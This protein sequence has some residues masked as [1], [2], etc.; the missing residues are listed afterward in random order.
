MTVMADVSVLNVELYGEAIG[1]LTR[2]AG[3]RSLFAFNEE[4]IEN[5]DRPTL[6]LFFKDEFGELRT[7][8]KPVQKQVMPFFSNLLPEGHLRKYLAEQAGVNAEREF[9]LLWALGRDL[10]GAITIK[11]ADGEIWPPEAAHVD[12]EDAPKSKDNMLRFSLAGVQLKFSAVEGASGGLTIPASGIGGDWIV[13]LPSRE[14]MGVPENEFSMMRLASM[15]GMDVPRIDLVDIDSIA[16]LPDG[17]DRFGTK[18]FVIERFDRHPSGERV[19]IEDFAQVF[20]VYG[21]DKYKKASMR[22]IAAVLGAEGSDEDIREFVRRLTFSTLIGNGDMH[23][24]NWSLIYPDRRT[25]ALS[26]AYDFVSTVP[27]IKDDSFALNYSRVRDFSAFDEDEISHLAAKAALPGK[28][29]LEVA[30][31]TTSDFASLWKREKDALPMLDDVRAAIDAL[32][33]TLPLMKKHL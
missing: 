29:V 20:G 31:E 17:T 26:P 2:V 18:A 25:A 22:N 5:P 16:N 3:D 1:T 19:H 4:Y 7:E 28:M 14:Y 9:F 11:P 13:K 8:F 33:P 6:S 12:G 27:Y 21:E 32:L 10:P 30:R 23:L 24:K 15:L